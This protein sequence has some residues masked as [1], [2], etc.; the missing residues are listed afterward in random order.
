[1]KRVITRCLSNSLHASGKAFR[2]RHCLIAC[3]SAV[4]FASLAGLGGC[5]DPDR[6]YQKALQSESISACQEVLEKHPDHPQA[7]EAKARLGKL[8][9]KAARQ[10]R[11][12][13]A[14]KSLVLD[15]PRA[16]F[17]KDANE[18]FDE[19]SW[20]DTQKKN[21]SHSYTQYLTTF[22]NGKYVAHARS[23]LE[24]LAWQMAIGSES[25]DELRKFISQFPESSHIV[26]A[27]QR[28]RYLR[29]RKYI[30]VFE[31]DNIGELKIL[32][33]GTLG[34]VVREIFGWPP[35]LL[36]A[37]SSSTK[38][39]AYLIDKGAD[40]NARGEDE[41]TAMHLAARSGSLDVAKLLVESKVQ[42]D[43][44][45]EKRMTV[46]YFGGGSFTRHTPKP[47]AR[48]GT[49]LHWATYFNQ[50]QVAALLIQN[51]ANVNADDGHGN[52][53][54]H[55]AAQA[56]N[57]DLIKTLVGAGA[58]WQGKK[59]KFSEPHATP[60]HYAKTV[61]IAEYFMKEGV[62]VDADSDMG[63]PIHAASHFGHVEVI[64]YL[65]AHGASLET[66]CFWRMGGLRAV[67]ATPLWIAASAG[68]TDV[69]DY[70]ANKGGDIRYTVDHGGSLLHAA[71]MNGHA[72]VITHLIEKGLGIDDKSG[73]PEASGMGGKWRSITPLGVA[74]DY[75]QLE[76][77]KA[78]VKAGAD[79]NATFS[80]HWNSSSNSLSMAIRD[81]NEQI[82][83]YL[84]KNRAK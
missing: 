4:L 22:P 52:M 73:F 67:H 11:N 70:L 42:I 62:A 19:L 48:V 1:M 31:S 34:R 76:A 29:K 59:N 84:R 82:A 47:T 46:I 69:I 36:A 56:G 83:A 17:A 12:I 60:L 32:D 7:A 28:I 25:I 33:N 43:A 2:K 80:D 13:D 81:K 39:A 66:T 14:V 54:I 65:L 3:M 26:K 21:T 15:F 40:V 68:R 18:L 23:E 20:K 5:S 38:I 49:P 8:L 71:A 57:M 41:A 75:C 45:I 37:D 16:G 79:V 6:D 72:N 77:V 74:V 9:W 64:G 63:Q 30:K 58:Q 51:G 35:L 55:L 27:E 61:E 53:P 50:P 24:K 10:S 78:L 44:F